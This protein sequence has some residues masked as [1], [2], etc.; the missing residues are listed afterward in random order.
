MVNKPCH[1]VCKP[2]YLVPVASQDKLGALRQEGHPALK[3]GD[4]GGGS[5]I[6]PDGVAPSQMVGVSA[7]VILPCTIKVQKKIFFW[8]RFTWVVQEK[9]L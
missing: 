2:A 9:G 6:S 8:H 3:M 5:L 4:V 1:W 7:F